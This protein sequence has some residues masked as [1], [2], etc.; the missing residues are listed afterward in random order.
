M[1]TESFKL[2][3]NTND[4]VKDLQNGNEF[5]DFSILNKNHKLF[6]NKNKNV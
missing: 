6:S 2:S 5:F 4:M 3:V 1:Y